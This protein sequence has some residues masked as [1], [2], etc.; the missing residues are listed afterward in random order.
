M[1]VRHLELYAMGCKKYLSRVLSGR[2]LLRCSKVDRG[3]HLTYHRSIHV[4]VG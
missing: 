2:I 3:M 4:V 1:G